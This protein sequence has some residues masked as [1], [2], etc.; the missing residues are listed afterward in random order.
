MF[1]FSFFF[2]GGMSI[3]EENK[4]QMQ[5]QNPVIPCLKRNINKQTQ[6]TNDASRQYEF[7]VKKV[8]CEDLQSD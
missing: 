7:D 6:N 5:L 3:V 1:I 4:P 2:L 8:L